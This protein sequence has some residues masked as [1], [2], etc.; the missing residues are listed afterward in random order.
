MIVHYLDTNTYR[1]IFREH[2]RVPARKKVALSYVSLMELLDQFERATEYTFYRDVPFPPIPDG[3][4]I[5]K[6]NPDEIRSVINSLPPF[7]RTTA[8]KTYQ[9]L[10]VCW[11]ALFKNVNPVGKK[12]AVVAK[13]Y[14]PAKYSSERIT[15][16][17][18]LTP[19][20]KIATEN[21][22]V[23]VRGTICGVLGD[24]WLK[25]SDIEFL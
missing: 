14:N 7:Q 8:A 17:S 24:F 25:R 10:E 6:P 12:C 11:Q 13:Y 19:K 2:L 3:V 20:L 4:K 9:G 18:V 5:T 22:P 21:E 15:C 23:I 16:D 1:R